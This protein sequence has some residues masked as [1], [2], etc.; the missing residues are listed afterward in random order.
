MLRPSKSPWLVTA[1]MLMILAT[2][3]SAQPTSPPNSPPK[4]TMGLTAPGTAGPTVSTTTGTGGLGSLFGGL[5]ISLLS[6]DREAQLLTNAV[7]FVQEFAQLSSLTSDEE[8][9]LVFFIFE[10]EKLNAIQNL[11]FGSGME[12]MPPAGL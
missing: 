7:T 3:A 4:S 9:I 12:P 1:G 8:M 5:G 2:S 11:F 6:A 10:I